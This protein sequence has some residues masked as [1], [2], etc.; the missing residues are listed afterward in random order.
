MAKAQKVDSVAW[1]MS[2]EPV[3]IYGEADIIRN[4]LTQ[5]YKADTT[6]QK[7]NLSGDIGSVLEYS[8]PV[9][10]RSSGSAG[11]T[12]SISLRGAGSD[13][14]VVYWNGF[15]VNS[16]TL[17]SADLSL[18]S[19]ISADKISVNTGALATGY[20]TATAGGS[21]D[22]HSDYN[23]QEN[24][25]LVN[26]SVGSYEN[27]GMAV[28][29]KLSLFNNKLKLQAAAFRNQS[30]NNF[31]YVD[32]KLIKPIE[33]TALHN[34]NLQEGFILGG[35]VNWSQKWYSEVGLW[36]QNNDKNIPL[37]LG[38]SGQ[39]FQE[40]YNHSIKQY[41]KVGFHK[42]KYR[43]ELRQAFFADEL[44]FTDRE[45]ANGPYTLN[46]KIPQ[47][48][49]FNELHFRYFVKE[50]LTYST[51]LSGNYIEAKTPNFGGKGKEDY[52]W[53][54]HHLNYAIKNLNILV[55]LRLDKRKGTSLQFLKSFSA[56]YFFPKLNTRIGI[57]V[58]EKFRAPDL[59]EKYWTPGGNPNLANE[60]GLNKEVN[61]AYVLAKEKLNLRTKAEY[62][63]NN[64]NNWIQWQPTS[65]GYWAP[66]SYKN[67]SLS[68]IVF[69]LGGKYKIFPQAYVG[70]T[71][72]HT[73]TQAIN[74]NFIAQ[75]G[76]TK[77]NRQ[78]PFVPENQTKALLRFGY[79]TAEILAG[80]NAVGLQYKD[81]RYMKSSVHHP[82][83]TAL[84]G[85]TYGFT[86]KKTSIKLAA[87][88]N[89]LFNIQ[90]ES[91]PNYVMPGRNF[92][93]SFT[94]KQ[95]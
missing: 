50:N 85:F 2:V 49:F 32:T 42:E 44:I 16:M 79:K 48:R 82:Y 8:T 23:F 71:A 52:Y 21:I 12:Q 60:K 74:K 88:I 24:E 69:N 33:K 72:T 67:V 31:S 36:V 7:I 92:L 22:L 93:I 5:P 47:N 94:I 87:T 38:Q 4:G 53:N 90:Y 59:N 15:P 25:V 64:I 28:K 73:I 77:V 91:V 75:D 80:V 6:L 14:T 57:Q 95:L 1:H 68:G 66:R 89:N 39:S 43:L 27:Y 9:F 18:V 34:Q 76:G 65:A 20:G 86:A 13:H 58:D 81:E 54:Y 45:V 26:T 62:Y 46:S 10:V 30:E 56:Q 17:G 37:L 83:K 55:G 29:T 78:V 51:S 35:K 19:N 70:L 3:D 41:A 61:I 84:L 11:A 63:H 40:Q